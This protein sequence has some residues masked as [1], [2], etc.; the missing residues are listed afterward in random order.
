[1]ATSKPVDAFALRSPIFCNWKVDRHAG[2]L[3]PY[4]WSAAMHVFGICTVGIILAFMA[5]VIVAVGG[6]EFRE[7][8]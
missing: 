6:R 1:M 8:S 5:K 4:R 7:P 3:A 2:C